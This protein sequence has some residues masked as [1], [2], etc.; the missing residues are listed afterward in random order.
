M[1][2]GKYLSLREAI[3]EGLLKRF[4]KEHKSTGDREQFDICL[5]AM[6]KTPSTDDTAKLAR[7]GRA[8]FDAVK[9]RILA[10]FR[11]L[12]LLAVPDFHDVKAIAFS[13]WHD[14]IEQI[15]GT[16]P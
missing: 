1:A 3:R 7:I 11:A 10:A 14:T 13:N 8:L 16:G 9:G 15:G 4:A 2:I 12:R 5:A 6:T